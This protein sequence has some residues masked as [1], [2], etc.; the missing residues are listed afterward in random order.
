MVP[1][2]IL[3]TNFGNTWS[4]ETMEIDGTKRDLENINAR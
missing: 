4:A 1:S 2:L 3:L